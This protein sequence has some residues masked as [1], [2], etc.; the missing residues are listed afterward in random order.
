L[1]IFAGEK[2]SDKINKK[3]LKIYEDAINE[4]SPSSKFD[5]QPAHPF[6]LSIPDGYERKVK[7]MLFGKETNGWQEDLNNNPQKA[8]DRYKRFWIDKESKFS[9]R[10]PLM[11]VFNEF[12]KT[13]GMEHV[14]CIWNNIIKIGKYDNSGE[15]PREIIDWQ[16]NWF[17]VVLREELKILT[18]DVVIFFTGPDYDKYIK[19]AFGGFDVLQ[20]INRETKQIAK[21]VFKDNQNFIAYRTY[22]P[23]HL[24][25]SELEKEFLNYL[26]KEICN[27]FHFHETVK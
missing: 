2:M 9:N 17:E 1:I 3:L 15:P 10:G 4:L 23:G 5:V 18:P 13:L 6:L 11:Q 20:V 19:K 21:I 16:Q 27:S 8:M 7:V 25:R 22:H 24:R 14:S 26:K 12:Q